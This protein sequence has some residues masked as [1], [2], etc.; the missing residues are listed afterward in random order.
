MSQEKWESITADNAPPGV[1]TPNMSDE[2]KLKWK[3]KYIGGVDKRIEIRK[4]FTHETKQR[5]GYWAQVLI[6]V[7]L[8]SEGEPHVVMSTNGKIAFS[9]EDMEN[10]FKA[11][12]EA[13]LILSQK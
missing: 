1:Y 8:S 3:A 13:K 4:V 2:D 6:V 9:E 12:K 10:Y 5:G 11:I 7:R